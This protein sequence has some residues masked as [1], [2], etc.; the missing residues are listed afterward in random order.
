MIR[1][2]LHS[3]WPALKGACDYMKE[4]FIIIACVVCVC[5]FMQ[6][7]CLD[8]CNIFRVCGS[9]YV[10]W[11]QSGKGKGKSGFISTGSACFEFFSL[12]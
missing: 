3:Q 1:I 6:M 9:P 12:Q 11:H 8:L 2:A 5:V 7:R 10:D 4:G